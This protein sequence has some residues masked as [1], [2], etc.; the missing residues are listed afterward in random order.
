LAEFKEPG[1][2]AAVRLRQ[3]RKPKQPRLKVEKPAPKERRKKKA[4]VAHWSEVHSARR[5]ILAHGDI[6]I[7][8][9]SDRPGFF[10]MWKTGNS[11]QRKLFPTL[12]AAEE[13][14]VVLKEAQ[15]VALNKLEESAPGAVELLAAFARKVGAA[16]LFNRL[17]Q[18]CVNIAGVPVMQAVDGYVKSLE[19]LGRAKSYIH[20]VRWAL[21]PL[22]GLKM[23]LHELTGPAVVEL[24]KK[25][26][27]PGTVTYVKTVL[28]GLWVYASRTGAVSKISE[29]PADALVPAKRTG[30]T[31]CVYT[32]EEMAR[33]LTCATSPEFL[34]FL[35]IGGFCGARPAEVLRLQWKCWRPESR[36]LVFP[37]NVTKTMRRRVCNLEDNAVAWMTLLS[38]GKSPEDLI[39]PLRLCDLHV[40]RALTALNSG[41]TWQQNALRHSYASYHLEKYSNAPLTAKNCGHQ[42]EVMETHYMQIVDKT[43]AGK[44]F[45]IVPAV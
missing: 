24:Y 1:S 29:C 42:V 45:N 34:A 17:M 9:V 40:E 21:K 10:V 31:P 27:A 15:E 5:Q 33:L 19:D 11:H 20:S 39:V 23:N 35:V 16:Q 2:G 30:R 12:L 41:V 43:T 36:S 3:R 28:Q 8:P 44:W 7:A 32:P 4:K 37:N 13:F 14:A 38:V 18:E 6:S 26:E 22:R 25:Y